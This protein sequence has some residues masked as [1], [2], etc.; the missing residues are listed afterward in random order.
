MS[1]NEFEPGTI[2]TID[3][4]D[5]LPRGHAHGRMN[6]FHAITGAPFICADS[7]GAVSILT[8]HQ[9][10]QL[11]LEGRA[12][13]L[14]CPQRVATAGWESPGLSFARSQVPAASIGTSSAP[15]PT[16]SFTKA[17]TRSIR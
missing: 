15:A 2:V 5:Y 3:G 8:E 7:N 12:R 9:F 1:F 16:C 6:L 14:P 17:P 11:M 4:A 13:S 10:G